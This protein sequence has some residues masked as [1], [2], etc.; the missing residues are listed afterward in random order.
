LRIRVE[1]SRPHTTEAERRAR[2]MM[3]EDRATYHQI[4]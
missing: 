4:C 1:Y 3:P 2:A